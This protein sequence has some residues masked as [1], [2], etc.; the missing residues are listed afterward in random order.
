MLGSADIARRLNAHSE[1]GQIAVCQ[2]LMLG[3]LSSR[4]ALSVLVGVLFKK[5]GLFLNTP[6]RVPYCFGMLHDFPNLLALSVW[7]YS[8][9]HHSVLVG[10]FDWTVN[11]IES[12]TRCLKSHYAQTRNQ[13]YEHRK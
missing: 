6:R 5:F 3:V 7:K 11:H 9:S 10:D 12:C 8:T 2:N 4:S 1:T 13:P